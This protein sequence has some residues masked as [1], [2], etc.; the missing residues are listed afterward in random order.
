MNRP[1]AHKR[2]QSAR[3]LSAPGRA[4]TD[5]AAAAAS[6]LDAVDCA[7]VPEALAMD[8]QRVSADARLACAFACQR[9]L[10]LPRNSTAAPVH[11][12]VTAHGRAAL[13][14]TPEVRAPAAGG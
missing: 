6:R 1:V 3:T 2:M 10:L 13:P 14:Q 12:L 7:D 11:R 4:S 5:C 8:L 9:Q